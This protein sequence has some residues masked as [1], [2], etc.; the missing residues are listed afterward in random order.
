MAAAETSIATKKRTCI[1][2]LASKLAKLSKGMELMMKDKGN[3]SKIKALRND[4]NGCWDS[5]AEENE[6][7]GVLPDADQTE[8][9]CA[10]DKA[11]IEFESLMKR[12]DD[13]ID[14]PSSVAGSRV[15]SSTK[16]SQ[17]KR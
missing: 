10:F 7:L 1:K 17:R 8:L 14:A 3:V 6:D 2:H 16:S 4:I 5:Y 15:S 12:V 13:W 9:T 11:R